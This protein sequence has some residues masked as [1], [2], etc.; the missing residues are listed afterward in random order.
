MLGQSLQPP[1]RYAVRWLFITACARRY[2]ESTDEEAHQLFHHQEVGSKVT[3]QA[4][5][6]GSTTPPL[7]SAGAIRAPA[8]QRGPIT[9][10][11][12]LI[13]NV[14][15]IPAKAGIPLLDFV[16][17][18]LVYCHSFANDLL[19]SNPELQRLEQVR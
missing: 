14:V 10:F 2:S 8:L 5:P 3:R 12:R 16:E 11:V 9:G 18:G 15:V 19:H 6:S 1:S 7:D 4:S 17:K 13:R